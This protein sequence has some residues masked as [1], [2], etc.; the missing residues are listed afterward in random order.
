MKKFMTTAAIVAT[1]TT[2]TFA[3]PGCGSADLACAVGTKDGNCEKIMPEICNAKKENLK[4]FGDKLS[5][6]YGQMMGKQLDMMKAQLNPNIEGEINSNLLAAGL[7]HTICG[8]DALLSEEE[9]K[10]V[11]NE[12]QTTMQAVQQKQMAEMQAKRATAG[13]AAESIGKAFLA[14]NKTKEGVITTESG[15]QYKVLTAGDGAKPKA[16]DKVEVHYRGTLV[17]GTEFDSSYKRGKTIEFPLNGVIKGWTEG[18]QLMSVGSKY[19]LYIPSELAY[20]PR[21][22]GA[23]IPPNSTLI[24]DI[25]LVSIK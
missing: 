14:E 17:D 18:V 13:K 21:G 2:Q 12:L 3:G 22:A 5:Y 10:K 1:M 15:L 8:Q 7:L 20:G 24:F 4:T 9:A 16:T 6:A 25:E 23:S 19:Q 11:M